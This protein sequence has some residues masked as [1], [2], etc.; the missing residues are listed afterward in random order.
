MLALI[1]IGQAGGGGG[2]ET[3]YTKREP[4]VP[5]V[6]KF[7]SSDSVSKAAVGMRVFPVLLKRSSAC[8][9]SRNLPIL[10]EGFNLL[11]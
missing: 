10:C 1:Y 5:S 7:L 8:C 9:L 2:E 6:E 3:K 11:A 4:E